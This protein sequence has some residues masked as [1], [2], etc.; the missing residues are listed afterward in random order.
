MT[1]RI[2]DFHGATVAT[3]QNLRGVLTF[4]RKHPVDVVKITVRGD[5]YRVVFYFWGWGAS[6][7]H[8]AE[9]QWADW[10]VLCDWLKA[11]RSWSITRI[12]ID[13][14]LTDTD[15]LERLRPLK[16]TL[17]HFGPKGHAS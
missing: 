10:R 12:N 4:A 17:L 16:G 5:R 11:R 7:H 13:P 8:S 1:V 6:L 9:T 2:C 14:A 3:S 15:I